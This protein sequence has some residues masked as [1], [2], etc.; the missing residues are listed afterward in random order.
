MNKLLSILILLAFMSL[1]RPALAQYAGIHAEGIQ[2]PTPPDWQIVHSKLYD[3]ELIRKG[4]DIHNWKELITYQDFR[5]TSKRPASPQAWLEAREAL[6]EKD[7]PGAAH[8]EVIQHDEFSILYESELVKPCLKAPA[9]EQMVEQHDLA[10]V[11]Y[12]KEDILFLQ[13][14]SKDLNLA[15]DVRS[16]W[17]DLLSTTAFNIDARIDQTIPFPAEEVIPALKAAMTSF[18]CKV[19]KSTATNVQCKRVWKQFMWVWKPPND[20]GGEK[21]TAILDPQGGHTRVRITTGFGFSGNLIKKNWA[22]PVFC[23]TMAALEKPKPQT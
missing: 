18:N 16:K 14:A 17:I 7:C 23:E 21:V 15:P 1:S 13:Y 11:V 20:S 19:V 22:Y 4:D 8:W 3:L 12:G 6:R 9:P 2:F 5:R 10:R